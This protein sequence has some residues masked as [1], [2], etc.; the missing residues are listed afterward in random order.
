MKATYRKNGSGP[1][2][3]RTKS[4]AASANS[5][6]E[7]PS[8]TRRALGAAPGSAAGM[9]PPAGLDAAAAFAR[10]AEA[11]VA[12]FAFALV[13]WVALMQPVLSSGGS[14]QARIVSATYPVGDVVLLAGFAGLLVSPAWRKPSFWLLV[15]AVVSLLGAER[16]DAAIAAA[17]HALELDLYVERSASTPLEGRGVLARW[18]TESRRLRIWTSTQTSTGVRAAGPPPQLRAPRL[19]RGVQLRVLER[20]HQYNHK[21]K[22]ESWLFTIARNLVIDMQRRKRP[23]L[24]DLLGG[25]GH[26]E[27]ALEIE[28]KDQLSALDEMTRQEEGERISAALSSLPANYLEVLTLRFQEDLS[29]E[30]IAGVVRA[31]LSTVKSRLYRGLSAARELWEER[32]P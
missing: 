1:W 17:P 7:K 28:A 23:Q 31:P 20:G 6:V 30:E 16:T 9:R 26:E 19:E 15:G 22:F 21:W 24:I 4:M 25:G 8:P 27:K 3:P 2:W 12:T 13:Q 14:L 11:G 18:D 32:E 5:S 10:C 29:L